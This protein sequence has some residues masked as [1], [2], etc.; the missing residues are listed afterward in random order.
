[1]A[2]T[3]LPTPI[4][5]ETMLRAIAYAITDAERANNPA[6]RQALQAAYDE[7]RAVAVIDAWC[8]KHSELWPPDA[9]DSDSRAG[10]ALLLTRE[11]PDLEP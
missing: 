4:P 6:K 11:D 1:M 7:L 10:F 5:H 3:P 2:S 8:K 9:D